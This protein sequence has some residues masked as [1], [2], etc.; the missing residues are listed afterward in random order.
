MRF[1]T[2]LTSTRVVISAPLDRPT[3][4]DID[5][6]F[7]DSEAMADELKPLTISQ[8]LNVISNSPP[9]ATLATSIAPLGPDSSRIEPTRSVA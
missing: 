5:G 7:A 9:G 2:L 4:S 8:M 1:L 6:Y 3:S